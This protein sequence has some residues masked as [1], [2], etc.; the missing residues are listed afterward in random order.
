MNANDQ[1]EFDKT[2][3]AAF[4]QVDTDKSGQIDTA[5]LEALIK[6]ISGELGMDS[7]SKESIAELMATMDTD[8]SGKINQKEFG[9]FL[10]K[11][12]GL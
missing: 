8:K 6:V 10:K 2:V 1:A 3:K 4:E 7:P 9:D 5:E 12:L 11:I